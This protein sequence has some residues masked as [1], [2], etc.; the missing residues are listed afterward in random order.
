MVHH[1]ISSKGQRKQNDAEGQWQ[2]K[3]AFTCFEHNGGGEHAGLVFDVAADEHDRADFGDDAAKGGNDSGK[4]AQPG[5]GESIA[6]S[7]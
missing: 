2:G 7:L 4:D 3:I 5:F 6:Y 1:K